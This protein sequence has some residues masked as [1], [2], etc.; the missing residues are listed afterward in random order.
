MFVPLSTGTAVILSPRSF[1]R[2]WETAQ[3]QLLLLLL[4]APL[5]WLPA[6][7]LH[8]RKAL[9][10]S[11]PS[12][13]LSSSP[14]GQL[15]G[16]DEMM[17]PPGSLPSSPTRSGHFLLWLPLLHEHLCSSSSPSVSS[18]TPPISLYLIEGKS[19]VFFFVFEPPA[20]GQTNDRS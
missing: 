5:L 9:F 6:A 2:T 18:V 15:P 3:P 13:P 10:A 7:P 14:P 11:L 4:P 19:K 8:S 12:M 16:P 17:P 1:L 20:P